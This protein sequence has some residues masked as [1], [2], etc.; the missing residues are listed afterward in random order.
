MA[1]GVRTNPPGLKKRK[2]KVSEVVHI[3]QSKANKTKQIASHD[4][5]I[6]K[7]RT[8]PTATQQQCLDYDLSQ[9]VKCAIIDIN[10]RN[11]RGPERLTFFTQLRC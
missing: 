10:N 8:K 2:K 7:K 6:Q 4:K 3:K 9:S 1:K 11:N 5:V